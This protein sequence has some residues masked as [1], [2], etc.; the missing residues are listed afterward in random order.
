MI[1]SWIWIR[2]L[3]PNSTDQSPLI[4]KGDNQKSVDKASQ[5]GCPSQFIG[6]I[7]IPN[8]P[9]SENMP[10]HS[11]IAP[12]VVA[13]SANKP[14]LVNVPVCNHTHELSS[15]SLSSIRPIVYIYPKDNNHINIPIQNNSPEGHTSD[16]DFG[17]SSYPADNTNSKHITSL[18]HTP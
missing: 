5:F 11:A 8:Q 10:A 2:L 15:S 9:V 6:P 3:I 7:H 4:H 13:Q 16:S 12:P 14:S 1:I 18:T 17:I